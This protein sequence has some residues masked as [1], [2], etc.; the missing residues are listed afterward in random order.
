M[1]SF[2]HA[3][4][5]ALP[6]RNWDESQTTVQRHQLG[7]IP[8]AVRFACL[9]SRLQLLESDYRW[10]TFYTSS[11][12]Q[13]RLAILRSANAFS[14]WHGIEF[15]RAKV[16]CRAAFRDMHMLAIHYIRIRYWFRLINNLAATGT[17]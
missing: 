16:T 10:Q 13:I 15:C 6:H 5:A 9:E 12:W 1:E 2:H 14:F 7:V 8:Q 3:I 4:Q 11:L 17:N